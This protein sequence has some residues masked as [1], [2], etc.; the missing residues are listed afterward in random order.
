VSLALFFDDLASDPR[1]ADLALPT[2]GKNITH[3]AQQLVEIVSFF[4]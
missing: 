2:L 1:T 3:H 4:L